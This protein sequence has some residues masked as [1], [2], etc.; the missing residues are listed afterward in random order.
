MKLFFKSRNTS[1]PAENTFELA[2][3][4]PKPPVHLPAKISLT[5]EQKEIL[6]QPVSSRVT[7]ILDQIYADRAAAER[8]LNARQILSFPSGDSGERH[9]IQDTNG[10]WRIVPGPAQTTPARLYDAL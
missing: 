6:D 10:F 1:A 8:A 7:R 2:P 3:A 9:V 5:A 4:I